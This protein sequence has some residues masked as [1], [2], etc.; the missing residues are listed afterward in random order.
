MGVPIDDQGGHV[1]LCGSETEDNV[2][3]AITRND[4]D[5]NLQLNNLKL[6]QNDIGTK[7]RICRRHVYLTCNPHLKLTRSTIWRH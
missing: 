6:K 4:P 5:E 2:W 7:S 1:E 3:S